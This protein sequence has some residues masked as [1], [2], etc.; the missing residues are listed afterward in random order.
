MIPVNSALPS[1]SPLSKKVLARG[2]LR[3]ATP[4]ESQYFSLTEHQADLVV[5]CDGP[6]GV[7]PQE[8]LKRFKK[9]SPICKDCTDKGLI[10]V[11]STPYT[12]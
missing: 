4:V 9:V 6:G 7:K 8:S 3:C 11:Q 2:G 10:P 12:K 5:Y 1:E